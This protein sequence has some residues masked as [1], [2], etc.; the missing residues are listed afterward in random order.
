MSTIEDKLFREQGPFS[1]VHL[2]KAIIFRNYIYKLDRKDV[3]YSPKKGFSLLKELYDKD[4]VP[5]LI[6]NVAYKKSSLY[7][8]SSLI[9]IE[10]MIRI[11][12]TS[13][14]NIIDEILGE[15][16]NKLLASEIWN[17]IKAKGG[18]KLTIDNLQ[19]A[20]FFLREFLP[21]YN[22]IT[23]DMPGGSHL[24][25]KSRTRESRKELSAPLEEL[26]SLKK[27]ISYEKGR[28]LSSISYILYLRQPLIIKT[29]DR[30]VKYS[31]SKKGVVEIDNQWY[32]PS[33]TV[34]INFV[35]EVNRLVQKKLLS[36]IY[37]ITKKVDTPVEIKYLKEVYINSYSK[38]PKIEELLKAVSS[39]K[40]YNSK[41]NIGFF[42]NKNGNFIVYKRVP[43]FKLYNSKA[44][45]VSYQ[46]G[47]YV[48][49]VLTLINGEISI[50]SDL[51]PMII[52]PSNHPGVSAANSPFRKLCSAAAFSRM[53]KYALSPSTY[54]ATAINQSF[55]SFVS[56][57]TSTKN[58]YRTPAGHNSGEN[59]RMV[60]TN[61]EIEEQLTK[62]AHKK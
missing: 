46:E 39:R 8:Y 15:K 27:I 31:L 52:L 45:E 57:Y 53:K 35:E 13:H 38:N 60:A 32:A 18:E 48:G 11:W 42:I 23:A 6:K 40:Y 24:K 56:G 51:S 59:E 34:N 20:N 12:L 36:S 47:N 9:S 54:V 5:N 37:E 41:K 49:V 29:K 22:D 7:H 1:G 3:V 62:R 26:S 30:A 14:E 28:F 10:D 44:K 17:E 19:L 50:R 16:T 21:V 2:E 55:N 43:E 33:E 61:F 25:T 4:N 58:V